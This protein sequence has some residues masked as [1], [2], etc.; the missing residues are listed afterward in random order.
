MLIPHLALGCG[1]SDEPN[2]TPRT[3]LNRCHILAV[4]SD[5]K[6]SPA[7]GTVVFWFHTHNP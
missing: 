7:L 1:H 6:L 4:P 5:L 2:T 3:V